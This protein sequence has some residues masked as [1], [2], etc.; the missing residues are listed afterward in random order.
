MLGQLSWDSFEAF[1]GNIPVYGTLINAISDPSGAQESDYSSCK[2]E[3]ECETCVK[4]MAI[5]FTGLYASS[6]LLHGAGDV[7]MIVSGASSA[8]LS[9]GL[10]LT[11]TVV[12]EIDT[13]ISA[14]IYQNKVEKIWKAEKNAIHTYCRKKR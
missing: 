1:L 8:K 5:K 4:K 11:I 3:K 6:Y 12:G 7:A 2:C 10:S 9:F 14:A 13:I